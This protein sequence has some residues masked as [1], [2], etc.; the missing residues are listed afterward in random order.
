MKVGGSKLSIG[1]VFRVVTRY[2]EYDKNHWMSHLNNDLEEST[3]KH[4]I[5]I[6][7]FHEELIKLYNQTFKDS[8]SKQ[9]LD[10]ISP[11]VE[12]WLVKL[13]LILM[14]FTLASHNY[15]LTLEKRY[16]TNTDSCYWFIHTSKWNMFSSILYPT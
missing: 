2:A 3:T 1:F 14:R 10:T 7:F 12:T 6:E 8:S 16:L 4:D 15:W 11:R 13:D 9:R 5:D